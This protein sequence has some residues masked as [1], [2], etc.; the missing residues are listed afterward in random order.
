MS[1]VSKISRTSLKSLD[2][3]I[4][5]GL[6]TDKALDTKAV[7]NN[8]GN[9]A[10]TPGGDLDDHSDKSPKTKL[11]ANQE[12]VTCFEETKACKERYAQMAIPDCNVAIAPAIDDDL[13]LFQERANKWPVR[14]DE[15]LHNVNQAL[16][17]CAFP[18][19][20]ILNEIEKSNG[21]LSYV[22]KA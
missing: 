8:D 20:A 7:S 3:S 5:L 19:I 17:E 22:Q 12:L 18:L 4:K 15:H 14:K 2:D 13:C 21:D 6:I 11:I 16:L 9:R 1:I 10:K